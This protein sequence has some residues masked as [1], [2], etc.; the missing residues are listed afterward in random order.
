MNSLANNLSEQFS[1]ATY[2]DSHGQDVFYVTKESYKS[3]VQFLKDK[4]DV[5]MCID[6]TAADFLTANQREQISGVEQTR[7]HLVS[8]FIS[9]KRNERIRLIVPIDEHDTTVDTISDIFPGANFAEREVYDMFGIVFTGHN[10]MTRILMP[11]EWEG[12]PLRKDDPAARIPV[13]FSDDI[14]RAGEK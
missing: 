11:D 8:N 9:H 12:F 10:D 6:V 14:A 3:I 4:C 5:N 7:F 13:N 2:V 1:E